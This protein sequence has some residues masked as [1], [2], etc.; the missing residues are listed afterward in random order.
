M[1]IL[2]ISF[3]PVSVT[4][5]G[6]IVILIL[7]IIFFWINFEK[8]K[9]FYRTKKFTELVKSMHENNV[10]SDGLIESFFKIKKVVIK[11]S[12]IE[13]IQQS[14][15]AIHEKIEGISTSIEEF[16]KNEQKSKAIS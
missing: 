2:Q 9:S 16:K 6:F 1:N 8:L 14:L 15:I 10:E 4:S 13:A 7:I 3:N 11:P 12:E 5:L